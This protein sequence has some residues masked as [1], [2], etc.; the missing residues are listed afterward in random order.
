VLWVERPDIAF[1]EDGGNHKK[2][3]CALTIL[4]NTSNATTFNQEDDIIAECEAMMENIIKKMEADSSYDSFEFERTNVTLQP[5]ERTSGD[6]A[7]GIRAEIE[8]LGAVNCDN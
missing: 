4:K 5:I 2:F 7:V 3:K 1:S 6:M 8:I